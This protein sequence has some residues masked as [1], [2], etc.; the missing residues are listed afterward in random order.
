[1]K[2]IGFYDNNRIELECRENYIK[3]GA[4]DTKEKLYIAIKNFVDGMG[5]RLHFKKNN[6][7]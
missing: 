2:A 1:M 6:N 5:P 7:S 3:I 4:Y